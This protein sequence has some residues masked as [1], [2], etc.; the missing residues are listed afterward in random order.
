M[1]KLDN[2]KKT[3]GIIQVEPL[4]T[5]VYCLIDSLIKEDLDLNIISDNS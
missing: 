3:S 5:T 1:E 2:L 4:E